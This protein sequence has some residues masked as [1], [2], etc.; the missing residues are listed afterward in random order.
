MVLYCAPNEK[1][2]KKKLFFQ[3]V[4]LQDKLEIDEQKIRFFLRKSF[5]NFPV[6]AWDLK[7]IFF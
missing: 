3:N 6:V 4:L 1:K 5:Q 7:K 2:E